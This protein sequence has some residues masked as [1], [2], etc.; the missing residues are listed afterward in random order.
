MI[1]LPP[2]KPPVIPPISQPLRS[3]CAAW[4]RGC[5]ETQPAEH[6]AW[7]HFTCC[8]P[9][10]SLAPVGAVDWNMQSNSNHPNCSDLLY[11]N[12]GFTCPINFSIC[13]Y[14]IYMKRVSGREQIY[15]VRK[16]HYR[17]CIIQCTGKLVNHTA[18]WFKDGSKV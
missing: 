8:A 10:A 14:T 18:H 15:Y 13:N 9:T 16:Q 1:P 17:S 7:D 11:L 2:G 6:P 12:H 4:L 3:C 5:W